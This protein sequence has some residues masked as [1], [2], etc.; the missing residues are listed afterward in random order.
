MNIQTKLDL[1][2]QQSDNRIMLDF[3]LRKAN[4]FSCEPLNPSSE[5]QI[6]A[7]NFLD[8]VLTPHTFRFQGDGHYRPTQLV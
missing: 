3:Q 7:F 4:C 2:N 6:F 5:I 8:I 1:V